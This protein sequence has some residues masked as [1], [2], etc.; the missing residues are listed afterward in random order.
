M[1]EFKS[2]EAADGLIAHLTNEPLEPGRARALTADGTLKVCFSHK[3]KIGLFPRLKTLAAALFPQPVEIF[4]FTGD[5][6]SVTHP[7]LAEVVERVA[8]VPSTKTY[9]ATSTK[10]DS[11]H[12][13][14]VIPIRKLYANPDIDMSSLSREGFFWGRVQS[15]LK[16]N[17]R[18]IRPAMLDRDPIPADQWRIQSDELRT[19]FLTDI[20]TDHKAPTIASK[21]TT[22]TGAVGASDDAEL[23]SE[24]KP[25]HNAATGLEFSMTRAALVSKH[26]HHWPTIKGDLK[27]A[28]INGLSIAKAGAR[29]WNEATALAWARAK[30]KLES[31]EKPADSLTQA[32]HNL[33][34]LSS[35]KH[36]IEG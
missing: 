11:L 28:A 10:V 9:Q 17:G 36:T 3:G 24:Y 34:I 21:K 16:R 15:T 20:N 33:S 26:L 30:C 32:M 1:N 25:K 27:S 6:Q 31:V 29:S 14:E 8:Q 23:S 19:A 18:V 2:L 7:Q 22:P 35:Q 12:P 13:F 4:D 5:L